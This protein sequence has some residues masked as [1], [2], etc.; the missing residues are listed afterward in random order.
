MIFDTT[1]CVIPH[2]KVHFKGYKLEG[3]FSNLYNTKCVGRGCEIIAPWNNV[4]Q[5]TFCII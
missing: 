4:S 3:L 5:N 2:I 1:N